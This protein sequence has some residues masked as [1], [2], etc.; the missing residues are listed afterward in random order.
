MFGLFVEHGPFQLINNES[1]VLRDYSWV[2]IM[3]LLYFDNPVGTGFSFTEHE[4]G[5]ATTEDDVARDLYSALQQFYTLFSEYR[6]RDFYL[7]G[8]SYAGKYVP[9]FGYLLHTKHLE[10][11]IK[12]KGIAIGNGFV[13]PEKM[14]D[15][16]SYFYQVSLF[17]QKQAE[18][19]RM[20]EQKMLDDIKNGRFLECIQKRDEYLSLPTSFFVNATGITFHYN[21]LLTDEPYD[22]KF[23]PNYLDKSQT[24]KAI[25]VG[26]KAFN[27][28]KTVL[29]YLQ[30]DRCKSAKQWLEVLMDNYKVLLYSGQLDI[31]DP[32]PL[33]D[34]MIKN[35]NWRGIDKYAE[36]KRTIWKL[37][38]KV[39]GY[40]KKYDQFYFMVI[41]DGGHMLPYDQPKAAFEMM[42]QFINDQL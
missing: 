16:S 34:N 40:L 20:Y 14:M 1:A 38:G 33:T 21:I 2:E 10:F 13:D 12:F 23:F 4:K 27:D 32:S 25:H 17:D 31:I 5:Y 7:T 15:H 9:A 29:K 35:C 41:R 36:Q 28:G 42:K 26:D 11:G 18:I 6:D 39:A 19:G 3:S 30:G 22:Q 8:E 37:D 24:R